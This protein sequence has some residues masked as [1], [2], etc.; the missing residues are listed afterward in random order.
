MRFWASVPA[1]QQ[2]VVTRW[3]A[4][5]GPQTPSWL[6]HLLESVASIRNHDAQSWHALA[7]CISLVLRTLGL[8]ASRRGIRNAATSRDRFA[9]VLEA[10]KLEHLGSIKCRLSKLECLE[11]DVRQE[12]R[13]LRVVARVCSKDASFQ[14][15]RACASSRSPSFLIRGR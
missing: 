7:C 3:Q 10:R 15:P 9:I 13:S 8:V 2:H 1:Q 14:S 11:V 5:S 12:R 4:L 6:R